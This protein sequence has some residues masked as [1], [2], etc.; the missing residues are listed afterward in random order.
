[1]LQVLNIAIR[2]VWKNLLIHVMLRRLRQQEHLLLCWRPI[3][4]YFFRGAT[5]IFVSTSIVALSRKKNYFRKE[6]VC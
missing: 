4:M 5:L 1:M 2:V 6:K 3:R